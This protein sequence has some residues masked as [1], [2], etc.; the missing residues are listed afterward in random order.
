MFF[1]YAPTSTLFGLSI[2]FDK[3]VGVIIIQS[4]C[5]KNVTLYT[6]LLLLSSVRKV[7]EYLLKEFPVKKK[8]NEAHRSIRGVL[9]K[10]PCVLD[11]NPL[12]KYANAIRISFPTDLYGSTL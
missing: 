4:I 12:R 2:K 1:A 10:T 8:E 11:H 5:T 3:I 7:S 6:C 9:R